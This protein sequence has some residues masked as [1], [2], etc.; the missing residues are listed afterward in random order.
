MYNFRGTSL[1][2]AVCLGSFLLASC[3]AKEESEVSLILPGPMTSTVQSAAAADGTPLVFS[4]TG[5]ITNRACYF[6]HVTAPDLNAPGTGGGGSSDPSCK[7][8]VSGLGKIFGP[9]KYG[10]DVTIKVP[11]GPGRVF[12]LMGFINPYANDP[13]CAMPWKYRLIAQP[14]GEQKTEFLYGNYVVDSEGTPPPGLQVPQGYDGKFLAFARSAP[15]DLAP[16]LV[17]VPLN[18][19]EMTDGAPTPY[20]C[21]GGGEGGNYDRIFPYMENGVVTTSS[22]QDFFLDIKCPDGAS[23]VSLRTTGYLNNTH[24][25]P[26]KSCIAGRAI[27]NG[28]R[29]S[30]TTGK[31]SCWFDW[32]KNNIND[33]GETSPCIEFQVTAGA[34]FSG[35]PFIEGRIQNQSMYRNVK[36]TPT[37]GAEVDLSINID[38]SKAKF[39]GYEK[40]GNSRKVFLGTGTGSNIN[41]G[42]R[43]DFIPQET[44]TSGFRTSS[45]NWDGNTSSFS[46]SQWPSGAPSMGDVVLGKIGA[47]TALFFTEYFASNYFGVVKFTPTQGYPKIVV[48]ATYSYFSSGSVLA[49]ENGM[50]VFASRAP[51]VELVIAP[52]PLGPTISVSSHDFV[53]GQIVRLQ[54]AVSG[55]CGVT[56]AAGTHFKVNVM[57]G[58]NFTLTMLPGGPDIVSNGSCSPTVYSTQF[59]ATRVSDFN[60]DVV[61]KVKIP[62][63]PGHDGAAYDSVSKIL[64]D[65]PSSGTKTIVST[66]QNGYGIL[67]TKCDSINVAS[68]CANARNYRI[69]SPVLVSGSDLLVGAGNPILL[70]LGFDAGSLSLRRYSLE[71]TGYTDLGAGVLHPPLA[72]GAVAGKLRSLR[73]LDQGINRPN[74]AILY[75][76]HSGGKDLYRTR[77]FGGNW[78]KVHR[79]PSQNTIHDIIPAHANTK[80]DDGDEHWEPSFLMLERHD[81]DPLP[82]TA[83]ELQVISQDWHGF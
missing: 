73:L 15:A 23:Q 83:Y 48:P 70:A 8:P 21:G 38:P 1:V 36:H 57:D 24:T 60:L 29:V 22:D 50:N 31:K 43:I 14:N 17:R 77:D 20:S 6:I 82:A 18:R 79:I 44:L 56:A 41:E 55:E 13:D 40:V 45:Y 25:Y 19:I 28:M 3:A 59:M 65:A 54:T 4:P 72:G 75:V 39:N 63:F 76:E 42:R 58:N 2:T 46:S 32:N 69:Q 67:V 5:L 37:S 26:N 35:T 7:V 34:T 80:N 62:M 52:I 11:S 81:V 16:G 33:S 66:S 47:A 71:S 30:D 51:A 64:L 49:T 53:N 68:N 27:F 78:Y 10:A 74:E 61:E 12:D 9:Y